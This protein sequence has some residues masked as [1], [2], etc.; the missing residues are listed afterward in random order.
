MAGPCP[1]WVLCD[2]PL[3]CLDAECSERCT[4]M[5]KVLEKWEA[6]LLDSYLSP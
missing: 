1:I 6:T 4:A 5:D 2:G 3:E